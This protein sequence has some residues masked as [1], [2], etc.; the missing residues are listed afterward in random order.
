MRKK[1]LSYI[2]AG[3]L[4]TAFFGTVLHFFYEWSNQNFLVGLFAPVNE[5]TWE[6]MK[7]L[8][9]PILLYGIFMDI[10]LGKD[11][12]CISLAYPIG[13]LAGTFLIPVM[14]YTYSGI[15][16][17][18]Y[19]PIDIL[20]FYISVIIAFTVIHIETSS[21]TEN[22]IHPGKKCLFPWLLV[23]LLAACFMIFTIYPPSLGIFREG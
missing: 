15:L 23:L 14:F 4:F 9:F 10:R 20:I 13:I 8:F 11:Y 12:P 7:L 19:T 18:N 6:H 2:I 1:L 21:C 16:G 17:K 3:I 22:N 5:S